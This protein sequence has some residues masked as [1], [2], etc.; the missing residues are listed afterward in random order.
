MYDETPATAKAKPFLLTSTN[1]HLYVPNL[2]LTLNHKSRLLD[3]GYVYSLYKVSR[4]RVPHVL[5]HKNVIKSPLQYMPI[6][7]DIF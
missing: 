5:I 4:N 6:N 7:E 3:K 2:Y 1:F